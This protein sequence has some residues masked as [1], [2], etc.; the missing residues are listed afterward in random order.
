MSYCIKRIIVIIISSFFISVSFCRET[1]KTSEINED[2]FIKTSDGKY[3]L[4]GELKVPAG[5]GKFPVVILIPGNGP[6]T[7][8]YSISGSAVFDQLAEFFIEQ[9]IAVL[10]IDK[11]GFGKSTG[12]ST[13]EDSTTTFDLADDVESWVKYLQGR[14]EIN[15][16]GIGLLGHSEGS[17]IASIVAS[18]KPDIKWVI[19]MAGPAVQGDKIFLEQRKTMMQRN[20]QINGDTMV[21]VLKE[22]ERLVNFIKTDDYRDK[23]KF[24]AI[25]HDFIVAHGVAESEISNKFIDKVLDAYPT[26]WYHRFFNIDPTDY[27]SK[28]K[29]PVLVVFA[30]NDLQVTLQQNILPLSSAVNNGDN[31]NVLISVLPGLD[32]FFLTYDGKTITKHVYGKMKIASSLLNT[33]QQWI[34]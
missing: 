8:H 32:H 23:Q 26:A 14:N 33:I 7:R 11:R 1:V 6:H 9:H 15:N 5:K 22:F 30:G 4:S 17:L 3:I 24:Y 2:I 20:G 31:K 34:N 27:I 21:A 12:P 10:Q 25:G 19:M 16:A 13:S 29:V 18:S 28:I